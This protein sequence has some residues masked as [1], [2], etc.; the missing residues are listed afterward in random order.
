MVIFNLV[1]FSNVPH[2]IKLNCVK[3]VVLNGTKNY[4]GTKGFFTCIV[5]VEICARVI[6]DFLWSTRETVFLRSVW[7]YFSTRTH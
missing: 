7:S 2:D 3:I 1:T 5:C 6:R 4:N